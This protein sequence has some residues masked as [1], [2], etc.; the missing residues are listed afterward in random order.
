VTL[1]S[2]REDYSGAGPGDSGGPVFAYRGMHSLVALMVSISQHRTRA[3]ALASHYG[4][5][6]DTVEKLGAP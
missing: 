2:V 3:V 1:I 4:W 6:K 5:I